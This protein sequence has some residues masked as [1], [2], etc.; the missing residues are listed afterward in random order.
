MHAISIEGLA[1][2]LPPDFLGRRAVLLS[3]ISLVVEQGSIHGL[4]GANGAGKSTTLRILVGAATPTSG[5][6]RLF[7]IP[8]ADPKARIGLGFAPDVAAHPASLS[9]REILELH[10]ALGPGSDTIDAVLAEVDLTSRQNDPVGRFSKGMQQR[11]S[12]AIALLGHPRLLVLDEPMSGLDPTGREL[13]RGI[14]RNR[15]AAGVTILFSS[16]VLSDIAELC[17]TVTVI[18]KGKTVFAGSLETIQ[19]NASGHRTVFG[20]K[21]GAALPAW[22]GPGTSR[23]KDDR[24][25][26]D[27]ASDAELEQALAAARSLGLSVITIESVRPRLADVLLGL[28]T[29]E[30]L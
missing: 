10:A 28:M 1:K 27:V 24:I 12:L 26:V 17:D 4:V 15:H 6:S 30:S 18:D 3:N 14:L 5:S 7:S 25:F 8:S 29:G 9:A 16:H 2:R 19:G 20:A 13:V 21:S 11:L 22:T 23:V